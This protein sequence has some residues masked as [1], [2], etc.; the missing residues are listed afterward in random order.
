MRIREDRPMSDQPG[1]SPSRL[2][3]SPSWTVLTDAPL[4]GLGLAREAG[5]ILVWDEADGL[6]LLDTR[7]RLRSVSRTQGRV[8]AGA[9]SDDGSLVALL[10][11][12]SRLWL[13]GPDFQMSVDRQGPPEASSLA[14][15]PHG[16]YVAVASKLGLT[17]LYNRHGRT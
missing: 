1:R 17:Q 9:I 8:L 4:R 12:G 10:G 7:G 6:Y 2:A 15:D 16:R 5:T 14:V 3:P 13:L 11:E